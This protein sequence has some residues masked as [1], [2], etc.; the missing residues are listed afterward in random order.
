MNDLLA[1]V[2][3]KAEFLREVLEGSRPPCTTIL[4]HPDDYAE[5]SPD[6]ELVTIAGLVVQTNHE[7]MGREAVERGGLAVG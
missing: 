5:M 3:K 6:G 4:L 2:T 7:E 1:K